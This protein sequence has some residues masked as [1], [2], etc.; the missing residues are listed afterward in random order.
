MNQN[1]HQS[2]GIP[3]WLKT[4]APDAWCGY[5]GR[6]FS[7]L[8]TFYAIILN[9]ISHQ[10][11]LRASALTYTT[12]LSLVP[13][14]AIAFSVLKGLGAHNAIEPMLASVAGES[15]DLV[16]KIIEYVNNTNVKSLGAV[17]LLALILT[18][19]SLLENIEEAFNTIWEVTENRTPQRR[20]SDYLSVVVVGPVLLLAAMSMNS[21]LQSQVLVK[22]LI[23]HTFFGDAILLLFRLLPYVSIWIAMLFL[24]IFIPNTRV[25]P[26]SALVGGMLAGTLWQVAQWGYF[27]FQVGMANYNAIYGTMAALPIFLVW[28]YT[29]WLIVLFGLEVVRAHQCR[30]H[31]P[32][33][34]LTVHVAAA[35]RE[36]LA[37]ALMIQVCRAFRHGGTPPT[38]DA[39][40]R[41]LDV[42]YPLLGEVIK[43]LAKL[44]LLLPTAVRGGKD[45]GWLPAREPEEILVTELL[46]AL[47]GVQA[48]ECLNASPV[49]ARA[50]TVL[51]L[52][53]NGT[54]NSLEGLTLR[55]LASDEATPAD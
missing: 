50:G 6:F 51:A 23:A 53:W 17:G 8:Q 44:G 5:Q 35:R 36:E 22:W 4:S 49:V 34:L 26:S 20:F 15:S 40:A 30:G 52:G 32:A 25:K 42:S 43:R 14:L 28:I 7:V 38:A 19:L 11:P 54:R 47:R 18:V 9:F 3:A 48:V 24:Y 21:A 1:K 41:E 2:N 27:H 31:G 37:L 46:A 12:V 13:F 45:S 29:S 55:D 16:V 10:G 33:G 39:L